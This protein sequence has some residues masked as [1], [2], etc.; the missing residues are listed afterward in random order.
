MSKLSI[1]E[2]AEELKRGGL[3]IVNGQVML[4]KDEHCAVG[5]CKMSPSY[6]L[7]ICYENEWSASKIHASL[8]D[9]IQNFDGSEDKANMQAFLDKLTSGKDLH[10]VYRLV[11]K[12]LYPNAL[13][14]D[15]LGMDLLIACNEGP[16]MANV[17]ERML[18]LLGYDSFEE[19]RA[20]VSVHRDWEITDMN[21]VIKELA[22][23]KSNAIPLGE[24]TEDVLM[25]IITTADKCNGAAAL[26]D[27]EYLM[28]L[29]ERFGDYYIIPSSRHEL[30][31]VP[32]TIA[33]S[34]GQH[35]SDMRT[36]IQEVNDTQVGYADVLSYDLFK[37][38]ERGL[39]IAAKANDD[40]EAA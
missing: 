3:E 14:E 36:M 7:V 26:L 40:N 31:L 13:S 4:S 21:T 18:K 33:D 16:F 2:Y 5:E 10:L 34:L 11:R 32:A 20:H 28:E 6:K 38:T 30:I 23:N 19:L 35:T 12:G 39:E 25:Y 22:K 27:T 1:E 24:I 17:T 15:F 9:A 8:I 29:R 37:F